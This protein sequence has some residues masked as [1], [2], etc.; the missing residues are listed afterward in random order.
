M[1]DK[2]SKPTEKNPELMILPRLA[3]KGLNFCLPGGF[4]I[5]KQKNLV[6]QSLKLQPGAV[7]PTRMAGMK[8]SG[9]IS[10]IG[11]F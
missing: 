9:F 7:H 4:P 2:P 3:R 1:D 6:L 5:E 10:S 8:H 11:A